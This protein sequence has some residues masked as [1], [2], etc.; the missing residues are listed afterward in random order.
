MRCS[1]KRG[2]KHLSLKN[3]VLDNEDIIKLILT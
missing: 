2:D 1:S 3:I